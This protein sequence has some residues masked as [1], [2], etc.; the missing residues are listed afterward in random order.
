MTELDENVTR[1]M[2]KYL[3]DTTIED[4]MMKHSKMFH[5]RVNLSRS[6]MEQDIEVLDLTPRAYNCLRRAGINKVGDLINKY[7]TKD[8]MSSKQ[9]LRRNRNL[10]E[11]TAIDILLK[12]FYYQ[13]SITP[14]EEKADYMRSVMESNEPVGI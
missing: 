2:N 7:S 4:I 11:K 3:N 12:L 1:E 8:T 14:E 5:F 13:F 6:Q 9:Q 10:G